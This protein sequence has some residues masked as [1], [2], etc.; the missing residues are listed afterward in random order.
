MWTKLSPSINPKLKTP[1][2]ENGVCKFHENWLQIDCEIVRNQ[3]NSF[4]LENVNLGIIP[5]SA[6]INFRRQNPSVE[7]DVCRRQILTSKVDPRTVRVKLFIMAVD[8]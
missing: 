5:Y 6:G 2:L 7:S 4:A 1:R 8:P 3:R